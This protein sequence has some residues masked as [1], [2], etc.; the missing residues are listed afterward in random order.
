VAN[1]FQKVVGFDRSVAL[2]SSALT[3]LIPL[4]IVA[5][6]F[7]SLLGGKDTAQRI[8]DRYELTGGGADAVREM[9]SPAGG[10]STSIGVVGFL[11]LLVA[12]LSFTRAVQRLFEQTWELKPMSVRNT[13]NG[14]I[15]AGGLIVY[16]G[17]S[18][19]LHAL[20]GRSSL[21]LGA[22]V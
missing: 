11:F 18:G 22:S 3:A 15:W 4:T 21:E 6:A 16:V 2:A 14:L 20:L 12:V 10:A 19:L 1:R 8:I 5:S 9:F 17:V 13:V 7:A